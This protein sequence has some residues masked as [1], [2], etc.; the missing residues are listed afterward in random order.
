MTVVWPNGMV[1]TVTEGLDVNT[2]IVVFYDEVVTGVQ[3]PDLQP[4]AFRVEQNYPN[5]FNPSTV[6]E[7]SLGVAEHVTLKIYTMVGEEV[8]TLV[9]GIQDAGLKFATWDGRDSKGNQVATGMYMYRI[10]TSS[11][12]EVR[13]MILMK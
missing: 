2:S 7:Y 3:N 6:I 9:D 10:K 5:P 8:T 12:V 11:S 4:E 13:K 1:S